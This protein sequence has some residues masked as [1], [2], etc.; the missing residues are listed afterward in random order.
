MNMALERIEEDGLVP[1]PHV[2]EVL[3]LFYSAENADI[4]RGIDVVEAKKKKLTTEICHKLH[5]DFLSEKE[6]REQ[7]KEAGDQ[8]QET[9]NEVSQAVNSVKNATSEF[10]TNIDGYSGKLNDDLSANELQGIL[11]EIRSDTRNMLEQNT[12]LEKQLERSN[13]IM[14]QL[15]SELEVAQKAAVTDSLTGLNN[16]KAFDAEMDRVTEEADEDGVTF[17]LIMMDIDHFKSFNDNFGHQVGDQVLR[18]VARTIVDAV[19]GKDIVARFGGEE[20]AIILP[21][22]NLIAALQVAE[23]LRKAVASKDIVNRANGQKLAKITLSAGV[24]ERL[25]NEAV[26]T[27]IARADKALYSAKHN[28]RNQAVTA[29]SHIQ[30]DEYGAA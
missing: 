29:P 13:V 15:K 27:L 30:Q 25:P 19:K 22:T 1:T 24:A 17:S 23:I 6:E 21:E 20:F 10:G 9:I 11:T 28:G 12:H 14:E 16:R 18:L 5:N 2:F 8:I 26:Q 4:T 3:Y 7:V